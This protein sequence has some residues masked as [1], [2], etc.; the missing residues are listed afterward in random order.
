MNNLMKEF[1]GKADILGVYISEAH[2][3]DEWPLGT[4]YCYNQPKEMETRLEIANTFV[5]DFKVE[6]PM[7]VDTMDNQFD[8][9]F[10]AWP[11]RFYIVHNDRVV[12]V[13]YPTTEFGFD[14]ETLRSTLHNIV[15]SL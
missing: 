7:L 9:S 1:E 10:A 6:T 15:N 11:E 13:G 8:N 2:A 5:K 12:F 3:E 14:R 4:K